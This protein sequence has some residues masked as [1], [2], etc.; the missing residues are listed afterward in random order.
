MSRGVACGGGRRCPCRS[1]SGQR[2]PDL[3]CGQRGSARPFFSAQ[4]TPADGAAFLGGHTT[5]LP[6]RG[7]QPTLLD[8][9]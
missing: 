8:K 5:S 9:G 4:L 6:G 1:P 3:D 2:G 7:L